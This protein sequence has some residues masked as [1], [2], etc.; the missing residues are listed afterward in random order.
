MRILNR[1]ASSIVIV[2]FV[3]LV[4]VFGATRLYPLLSGPSLSLSTPPFVSIEGGAVTISGTVA[5]SSQLTVAGMQV[6]PTDDG[7]FS[8]ELFVQDGHTILTVV[9][10]DRRGRSVAREVSVYS[11]KTEWYGTQKSEED[12][13]GENGGENPEDNG[14]EE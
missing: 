13:I 5:R 14:R 7:Q 10:R 3:L 2:C 12:E 6:I 8:R 1:S 4:L 9:A 11:H